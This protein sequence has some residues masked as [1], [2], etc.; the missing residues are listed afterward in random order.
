MS[1]DARIRK[2]F[3][4]GGKLSR[5]LIFQAHYARPSVDEYFVAEKDNKYFSRIPNGGEHGRID[6]EQYTDWNDKLTVTTNDDDRAAII[7]EFNAPAA[8]YDLK[9]VLVKDFIQNEA[10][11]LRYHGFPKSLTQI[12]VKFVLGPS[13]WQPIYCPI[14]NSLIK[15]WFDNAFGLTMQSG[16]KFS[17]VYCIETMNFNKLFD[18]MDDPLGNM[19]DHCATKQHK[20]QVQ[21][22]QLTNTV[23]ANRNTLMYHR[24]PGISSPRPRRGL[25]TRSGRRTRHHGRICSSKPGSFF[26][27]RK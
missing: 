18:L 22:W 3:T 27:H 11:P 20:D 19:I 2:H 7:D 23:I 8:E 21:K 26:V 25:S 4:R 24:K 13:L 12:I 9:L 10:D 5:R 15:E 6:M 1:M 16:G 14:T 17:C